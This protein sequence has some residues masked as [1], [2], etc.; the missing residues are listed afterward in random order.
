MK[1]V[2]TRRD[3]MKKSAYTVMGAAVGLTPPKSEKKISRVVLIRHKDVLDENF[4]INKKIIQ[5]MFD[6]ALQTLFRTDDPVKTMKKLIK[7]DDIVGIKSNE[8][9]YLPTPA[10]LEQAIKHR[11]LDA[12]V[13][14]ENIAIDDRGVRKN[15]IFQKATALINVRPLRTH[16]LAGMSGCM[17]NYITF[18]KNY[19]DYHPNNCANLALL[20][21]L[22]MVKG[23]TKLNILS[24]L[25]PQFHGRG[26]HH[27]N[28]RYVWDYKGILVGTDPVAVDTAGLK[29]LL[30]KRKEYFKSRYRLFP[31]PRYI[32]L[33]D[34][35]HGLGTGD[36]NKIEL[37]KLGWE[38]GILI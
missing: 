12:G 16:Y 29:I 11:I 10:E 37:I 20:F 17:K 30:A 1:K 13:K 33:A 34:E 25:T 14:E 2:I 31:I 9:N 36:W 24:V 22:P 3:F 35:K 4:T 23:K 27:F 5:Q 26:P 15:P 28:R 18:A 38:E 8:W 21:N 6:E 32:Q 7:P 19:P